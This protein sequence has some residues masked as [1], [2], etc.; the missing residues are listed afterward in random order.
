M[1]A[2]LVRKMLW[3]R[4]IRSIQEL[5]GSPA[6]SNPS[7]SSIECIRCL[8]LIYIRPLNDH[9]NRRGLRAGASTA[10]GRSPCTSSRQGITMAPR[11]F[12][13]SRR[14]AESSR[15][16]ELIRLVGGERRPIL[17]LR[18]SGGGLGVP[19]DTCVAAC[20]E[21]VARFGLPVPP[22]SRQSGT[23]SP[24]NCRSARRSSSPGSSPQSST[25]TSSW[26]SVTPEDRGP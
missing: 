3:C 6:Y 11:A 24:G 17:A 9:R 16:S 8:L 20:S 19:T 1:R 25:R 14:P 23:C 12:R 18:E 15:V 10:D 13:R 2:V 21:G 7:Y 4:D 22:R 5:T 26:P